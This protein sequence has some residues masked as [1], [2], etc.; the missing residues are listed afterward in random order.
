MAKFGSSDELRPEIAI[1]RNVEAASTYLHRKID[2]IF[3]ENYKCSLNILLH[4]ALRNREM[5]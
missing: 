5:V 1:Y 2:A 4:F 3:P